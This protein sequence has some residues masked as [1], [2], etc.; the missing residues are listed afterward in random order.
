MARA[1]CDQGKLA[2]L[3]DALYT[4][5]ENRASMAKHIV[6]DDHRY[7]RWQTAAEEASRAFQRHG[8]VEIGRKELAV[9]VEDPDGSA[10]G[11]NAAWDVFDSAV[12]LCLDVVFVWSLQELRNSFVLG[13]LA[14]GRWD[15]CGARR[16]GLSSRRS[17]GVAS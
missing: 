14:L 11:K 9:L 3:D 4:R 16:P 8:K 2:V 17:Q 6:S 13:T 5:E 10:G 15:T 1:Y 12:R 7:A